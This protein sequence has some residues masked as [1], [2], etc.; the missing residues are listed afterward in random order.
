MRGAIIVAA[1]MLLGCD[2]GEF[3]PK[4]D[5]EPIVVTQRGHITQYPR[6]EL[7]GLDSQ[8]SGYT[9]ERLNFNAD[10]IFI[11]NGGASLASGHVNFDGHET[12]TSLINGPV[13]FL[14]SGVYALRVHIHPSE[15]GRSFE[16]SIRPG[17]R[18]D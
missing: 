11:S 3:V 5:Y 10:L 4:D 7:T 18:I 8:I 13:T 17:P 16:M 15:N 12:H 6:I 9:V 1:V 14:S 2:D